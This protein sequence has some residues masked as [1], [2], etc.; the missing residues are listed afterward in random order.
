MINQIHIT[1]NS[2]LST[3]LKQQ[4]VQEQVIQEQLKQTKLGRVTETPV[5]MTLSQWWQQWQEGCLLRGEL[6][7]EE[8]NR[9]VLSRFESQ[10]LWEQ[11]LQQQLIQREKGGNQDTTQATTQASV[12]S[13]S[14]PSIALLNVLSTAKLLQQAWALSQEW[15]EPSWLNGSE[16]SDEVV[17][18]KQCQT[19]Y[20]QAL[21]KHHWSDEVLEQKRL[22]RWLQQGKGGLPQAFCLHGFDELTPFMQ[23][24]QDTVIERG[25]ACQCMDMPSATNI[26]PPQQ[27]TARDSQ[28]EVQQVALWCVT[29]WQRLVQIK[30][31][32]EIKIG[33]VSPNIEDY[34][35]TLSH[36]LDEQLSLHGLQALN[37]QRTT[38]PFY[39]FSLGKPLLE[40]PLVQNA[41]LSLQLLLMPKKPCAYREWS[42]WL[43]SVYTVGDL[44]QRQQADS[45]FRALQWANLCWPNLLETQAGKQLPERLK[46]LLI[47]YASTPQA[48]SG[49]CIR[50]PEFIELVWQT[51]EQAGWTI[52]RT[53]NSDEYQQKEAFESAVLQFSTLTE[54][55]GKH[56]LSTWLTRLKQFLG[57]QL[58]QSQ[59]KGLQP[60]QIMG[61]LEA[62]GQIFDALWVLG[63]SDT[64]WPSS[65]NPNPFL[66]IALQRERRSLRCDAQRELEYAQKVTDRLMQ[67]A[68]HIVCSYAQ[69]QDDAEQLPSPL[70]A[71]RDLE[72]YLPQPYQSFALAH[73]HAQSNS[74]ACLVWQ[75]DAQAPELPKGTRA[76][77]GTGFLQAQSQCPLMAFMDYR[78]GAKYGLQSVE[79][80]LQST[81]QGRLVH[82][83]LERFWQETKTQIAMLAL[84]DTAMQKRLMNHIIDCFS[85]QPVTLDSFYLKLEQQRIFD[86]CWAWLTLEKTRPSFS[87]IETEKQYQIELGG[88][89]FTLV[90]DRVDEVD[91]KRVIIDYKTGKA[92]IKQLLK[93]PTKAPQLAAYL[94][95]ITQDVSGIG[96]GML[97]SDDGVSI[98]AIVEETDVLNKAHTVQVFAKKAEKEGGEFFDVAWNDF[99]DHLKQ[100]VQILAEQIQQGQAPMV[101]EKETDIQYAH[102]KL[103]L[104]LPEVKLQS[105]GLLA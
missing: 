35:T 32:H 90:I 20:I 68:P 57:E 64:A 12:Q 24:W 94:H 50:L 62:G 86:L 96:Y 58:H 33:V 99:L 60:I 82:E 47:T 71:T 74:D 101:F 48:S 44:V 89:Q 30:P 77:G 53:L 36:H 10:W 63:L 79:E 54:V 73:R 11:A 38:V 40:F 13:G 46:S 37:T 66:P 61:T 91:E 17:L 49:K 104:R 9:K 18:F 102:C 19:Y 7:K 34:K 65:A 97:H 45:A 52:E 75:V 27:Y 14:L 55:M 85:A 39:N 16:H 95:A 1:A 69:Q 83:V 4:L 81:N 8:C 42:Q 103:A 59:S 29:Q 28:D 56:S 84:S 43:T 78:L 41:L 26:S 67:S 87:V 93:T 72:P 15:F 25:V 105:T 76:P 100:Q 98:S 92:S 70:M 21:E 6:T 2:R 5:V 31:K 80:G 88:I 3:T 51:L 22:L 23:Q